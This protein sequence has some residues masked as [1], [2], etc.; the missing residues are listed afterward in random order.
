[1][2]TDKLLELA[3]NIAGIASSIERKVLYFLV[4]ST[5]SASFIGWH[6]IDFSS[7]NFVLLMKLIF[8]SIPL[9]FWF[10]LWNLIKQLMT[11]PEKVAELKTLGKES[12]T[13][14]KEFQQGKAKKRNIF[15]TLFNLINTLR[16]PEILGTLYT[17]IKGISL[18][19]NPLALAAIFISGFIM[20][21]YIFAMIIF[22][23]F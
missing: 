18:L 8:L 4:I 3:N 16:E 20:L 22:A 17:C 12:L 10:L 19:I 7:V 14:T 11:L 1:M 23:I 13:L 9:F 2:D 15:F 21:F 5:L 6:W